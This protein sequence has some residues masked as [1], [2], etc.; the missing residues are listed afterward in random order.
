MAI[1]FVLLGAG[2]VALLIFVPM[3]MSTKSA[4][5]PEGVLQRL[6]DNLGHQMTQPSDESFHF[7]NGHHD[8]E[9]RIFKASHAKAEIHSDDWGMS[10]ETPIK[11]KFLSKVMICRGSF[12]NV[13]GNTL[14]VTDHRVIT[15]KS[16]VSLLAYGQKLH[17]LDEVQVPDH[18][19]MQLNNLLIFFRTLHLKGDKLF[20]SGTLLLS[21]SHKD[22][23]TCASAVSNFATFLDENVK[24]KAPKKIPEM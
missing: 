4:D 16:G 17:W 5:T 23:Q 6:K 3:M 7:T 13:I 20:V 2:V 19:I 22:L 18:I 10:L 8:L 15:S 21:F 11:Q 9:F 24:I 14:A 1:F 12:I